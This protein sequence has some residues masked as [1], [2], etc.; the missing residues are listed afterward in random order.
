MKQK[1]WCCETEIE[2]DIYCES[3]KK[4]G[5]YKLV[6][7]SPPAFSGTTEGKGHLDTSSTFDKF[8]IPTDAKNILKKMEQDGVE[9]RNPKLWAAAKYKYKKIMAKEHTYPHVDYQ[10]TG[11]PAE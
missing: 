7:I 3:C 5:A 10:K 1:C 2:E 4:T 8:H 9:K 11:H 6:H